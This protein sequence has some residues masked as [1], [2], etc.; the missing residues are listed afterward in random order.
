MY[1]SPFSNQGHDLAH[2]LS[3]FL[4]DR[5]YGAI[6]ADGERTLAAST[7][8]PWKAKLEPRSK[9]LAEAQASP[10]LTM[11]QVTPEHLGKTHDM[12]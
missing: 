4:Y 2:I 6:I 9:L 12:N 3:T 7:E 10:T 5:L 11:A 1:S 8:P